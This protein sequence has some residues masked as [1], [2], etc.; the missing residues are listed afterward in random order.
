MT[1]S[2]VACDPASG[3]WGVAV[4]SKCLAVGHVVP[5]GAAGAGAIAT[6]A[7]ANVSYGPRGL[8]LLRAGRTA[9]GTLEA[10]VKDDPLASRRQVGAVDAAGQPASYTGDECLPWAGGI[11]DAGATGAGSGVAV[12]GNLL[13]GE[14]VVAAMLEAYRAGADDGLSLRLLAALR[15]GDAAGGDR[16]GRQSAAMRI[17]R[18]D[19]SYGGGLDVALDLRV[20]DHAHPVEELA[21]LERLHVLYFCRPDPAGLL[22]LEGDL[23]N[24]VE[25]L[26]AGIGLDPA[27]RGMAAALEEWVGTENFE[28]RHVP[29]RIDPL[30]LE[31]LR[32][33]PAAALFDAQQTEP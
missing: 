3:S 6:Q 2:I 11:V 17:W 33:A 25:R 30:V 9:P 10:L 18:Q 24:E 15:A 4:A 16:R 8:D 21:R 13:A 7:L 19:A 23:A 22:V 20:D 12:Q 32:R 31:H 1:F 5:W 28:E 14:Q 27:R 26:L 29:G